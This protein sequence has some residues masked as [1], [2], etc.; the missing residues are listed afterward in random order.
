MLN[1]DLR[2]LELVREVAATGSLTAAGKRLNVTQS[3]LSH[4][5]QELEGRLGAPLFERQTRRMVLTRAG[6]R[7]V[8]TATRVLGEI[9]VA[10]DETRALAGSGVGKLRLST[11][12]YTGY[13]WLGEVLAEFRALHPGI[14]VV[15]DADSTRCAVDAVRAGTLD[16][17]L[18]PG[19][20]ED[21]QLEAEALFE[22]EVV[23]LLPCAHP[24][25]SEPWIE[26]S[27]LR[28]EH[29]VGYSADPK[30]SFFLGGVLG[31]AGVTPRRVTG[32]PL[33]EAI[34]ELVK[35]GQGVAALARWA[36][37]PELEQGGL[38]AR[39]YGGPQGLRRSWHAVTLRRDSRPGHLV[40]FIHVLQ[41]RLPALV[42]SALSG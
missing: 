7:L 13:A 21:A 4:R 28:D 20:C 19:P 10:W 11:A 24:L 22:D 34:V 15:V 35:A 29:L 36:V 40:A 42:G 2:D 26:A 14:E 31:P 38:V 25:V 1:L 16:L 12:C 18:A 3:A 9:R 32:V 33:T 5:L 41:R 8:E 23:V 27:H 17:A 6:E 39:P 30:Q 37:A